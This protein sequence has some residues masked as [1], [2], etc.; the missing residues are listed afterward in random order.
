L[1]AGA[2]AIPPAGS[3]D[4]DRQQSKAIKI[5]VQVSDLIT[6]LESRGVDVSA[7]RGNLDL[8]RS[9]V[10]AQNPTKAIQYA[11]KADTLARASRDR[12]ETSSPDRPK[13]PAGPRICPGCGATLE[14]GWKACPGCGRRGL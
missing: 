11:N 13:P 12:A 4:G 7:A 6:S 14:A 1:T 5:V 2:A 10:R 3:S 8:A 9:F